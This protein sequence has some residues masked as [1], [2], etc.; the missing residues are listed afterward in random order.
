MCYYLS[1]TGNCLLKPYRIW[2]IMIYFVLPDRFGLSGSRLLLFQIVSF[3]G[4]HLET[5]FPLLLDVKCTWFKVN[6]WKDEILWSKIPR[7]FVTAISGIVQ[8]ICD[9]GSLSPN[10]KIDYILTSHFAFGLCCFAQL[11]NN[12][13][14][15]ECGA[16]SSYS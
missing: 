14:S 11:E 8:C 15:E 10:P 12:N 2:L 7:Q 6:Y 4:S 3:S 13:N 5:N 9:G 1:Q 16:F